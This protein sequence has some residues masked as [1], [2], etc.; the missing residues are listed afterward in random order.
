M[1]RW[2]YYSAYG[3][4][5]WL[6]IYI[7]Q[8]NV[9]DCPRSNL[10]YCVLVKGGRLGLDSVEHSSSRALIG[11]GGQRVQISLMNTSESAPKFQSDTMI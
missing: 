11:I 9:M 7:P 8:M 6:N 5:T 3:V 1:Q 4:S 2:L 10:S